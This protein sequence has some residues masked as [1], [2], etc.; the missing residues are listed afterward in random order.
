M[1][2][3]P[4]HINRYNESYEFLLEYPKEAPNE[5][6]RWI[7]NIDP[8]TLSEKNMTEAPGFIPIHLN[9]NPFQGLLL[10]SGNTALL[11]GC[12]GSHYWW[13]AIG[14]YSGYYKNC[15]PGPLFPKGDNI[16]DFKRLNVTEVSL[17]IHVSPLFQKCTY[18]H[19]N[20]RSFLSFQIIL[21]CYYS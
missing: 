20:T 2:S 18:N 21:V 11:D 12:V 16:E 3:S 6:N 10:S 8:L 19:Y 7:Q 9:W 15:T 13:Y 1:L 4:N 17:W 14:D 5:Y